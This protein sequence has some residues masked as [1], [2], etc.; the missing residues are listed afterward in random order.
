MKKV[1]F[2]IALALLV[3]GFISSCT[4]ESVEDQNTEQGIE[5]D[6]VKEGDI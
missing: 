1:F 2:T 5:N 3:V 6:E 4:P